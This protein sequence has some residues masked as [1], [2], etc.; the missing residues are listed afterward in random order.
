MRRCTE[1]GGGGSLP[2]K[3]EGEEEKEIKM[4]GREKFCTQ[5]STGY[6]YSE[7][8]QSVASARVQRQQQHRQMQIRQ[9]KVLGKFFSFSPLTRS[10]SLTIYLQSDDKQQQ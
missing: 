7:R 9:H 4:G 2:S 1:M 3:E 10:L 8:S 5:Q 6:R